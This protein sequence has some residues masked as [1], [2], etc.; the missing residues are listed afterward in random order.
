[1]TPA[2]VRQRSLASRIWSHAVDAVFPPRC[3]SCRAFGSFVCDVCLAR[4]A[5]AQHPRCG[6]CW[7][8]S[9]DSRCE[10]CRGDPPAFTAVRSVYAY[11]GPARD[12]VHALKYSGLSAVAPQM[13][14][15]M[16][17]L[18]L[19]WR[20]GI[21]QIVPVPMAGSRERRRGYN[22]SMLLAREIGRLAGVPVAGRALVRRGSQSQVEQPDEASRRAN[23]KDAF[24]AGR[25]VVADR[26]LLIDDA[27][28]T[29]ATLD[30]CALV[31]TSAGADQV[32]G[33]TFARES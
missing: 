33:L 24:A 14:E 3:V 21:T 18:L 4:M 23:V 20:P 25:E 19:D 2:L 8:P 29:G 11:G 12:L 5:R 9:A 28:T 31:L 6:V 32:Y 22:Q 30:A 15:E 26:V 13:G 10:H 7:Q 16:A 17:S 1:M 27:M